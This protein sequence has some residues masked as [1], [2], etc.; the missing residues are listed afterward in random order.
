MFEIHVLDKNVKEQPDTSSFGGMLMGL[1]KGL[2]KVRFF[3]FQGNESRDCDK[4]K[5]RKINNVI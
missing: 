1:G 4:N 2:V 3:V 5:R